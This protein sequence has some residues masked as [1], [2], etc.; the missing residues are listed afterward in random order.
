MLQGNH[1][2]AIGHLQTAVAVQPGS[3][4]AH[5]FLAEAYEKA[6]KSAE[7][8]AEREKAKALRVK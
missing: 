1:E 8:A 2:A 7:A 5:Q 3:A 4:E 6:G